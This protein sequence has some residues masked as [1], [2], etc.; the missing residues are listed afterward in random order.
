M[1]LRVTATGKT[2]GFV[3]IVYAILCFIFGF[4]IIPPNEWLNWFTAI[5]GVLGFFFLVRGIKIFK[6]YSNR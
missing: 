3:N 1:P 4:T 6:Y 2:A 5:F